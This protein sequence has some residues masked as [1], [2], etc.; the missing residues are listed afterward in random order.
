MG[1]IPEKT[2]LLHG[3]VYPKMPKSPLH[4]LLVL[5]LLQMMQRCLPSGHFLQSEQPLTFTDS[6]PEPDVSIVRGSVEDFQQNHPEPAELVVE[7]CV[8]SHDYDREKLGAYAN[9]KVMEVWLV[10]GP[11]RQVEVFRRPAADRYSEFEVF[12]S[13]GILAT[14]A[15]PE[16]R[17]PL[18]ELFRS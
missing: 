18:A 10:L 3:Q 13:D 16:V 6:E 7:V 15:L 1:L 11:E 2:E 17:V 14:A 4:R 9:A 5:R 12:P 8:S